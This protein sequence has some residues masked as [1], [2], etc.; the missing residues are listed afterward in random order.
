M[1]KTFM[2]L[3]VTQFMTQ[4]AKELTAYC[5]KCRAKSVIKDPQKVTLK[6]GRPATKGT[7]SKCG[8]N[9]FRIG[10]S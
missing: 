7:C 5:V 3:L 4:E 2:L 6:N 8:T 9:V 1:H 10:K